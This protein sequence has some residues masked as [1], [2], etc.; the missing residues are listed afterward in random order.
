MWTYTNSEQNWLDGTI[1]GQKTSA[2][3]KLRAAFAVLRKKI[4]VWERR[5]RERNWLADMADRDLRDIRLSR[6][7]AEVEASKPFWKA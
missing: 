1:T 5:S 2:G 3:G 4:Q 7:E 6:F